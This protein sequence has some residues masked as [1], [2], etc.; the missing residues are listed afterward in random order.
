MMGLE[1]G[2]PHLNALALIARF[3][4]RLRFH[5]SS[6]HVTSVLI[7]IAHDPARR[8]VRAATR[9]ERTGPA[10]QHRCDVADC[11]I[12]T[13]MPSGDQ[14]LSCRA[15]IDIPLAV[16]LKL[17]PREC[18]IISLAHVPHW[19]MRDDTGTDHEGEEL[20]GTVGGVGSKPLRL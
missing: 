17:G 8:H 9:L 10:V 4:K 19:N 7:D 1:M 14:L 15:D 6:S 3:E 5:L 11:V 20:A 13:D 18:T 16:E 2:E 12:G